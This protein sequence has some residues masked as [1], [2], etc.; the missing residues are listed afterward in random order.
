MWCGGKRKNEKEF[1]TFKEIGDILE[2]GNVGV[3]VSAILN[4]S[5]RRVPTIVHS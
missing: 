1:L 3:T 5:K 4:I 2:L